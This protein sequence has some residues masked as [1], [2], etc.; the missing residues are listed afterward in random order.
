MRKMRSPAEEK[1]V[2]P[3][4]PPIMPPPWLVLDP[5]P[6]WLL[7]GVL[8]LEH[9]AMTV[10]TINKTRQNVGIDANVRVCMTTPINKVLVPSEE[11]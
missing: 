3:E 10:V 2:D 8:G 4:L 7:L 1:L 11:G 9:P 5:L 6:V